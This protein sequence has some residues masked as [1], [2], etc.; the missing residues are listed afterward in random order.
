MVSPPS[1]GTLG[2]PRATWS[3]VGWAWAGVAVAAYRSPPVV[4]GL[5][6][7]CCDGCGSRLSRLGVVLS[8]LRQHADGRKKFSSPPPTRPRVEAAVSCGGATAA[9]SPGANTPPLPAG[10]HVCLGQGAARWAAQHPTP[11]S[12]GDGA[13]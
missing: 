3:C 7:G 13:S 5:L 10:A 6:V 9:M 11:V 8:L 2:L 4:T 1:R 12:I